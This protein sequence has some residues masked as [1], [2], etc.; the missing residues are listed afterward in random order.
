MKLV[1][2][3]RR[4]LSQSFRFGQTIADV[5][6][7]ILAGPEVPTDLVMEGLPSIPSPAH[8]RR[9][10]YYLY[11]TNAGVAGPG[12]HERYDRG[13]ARSAHGLVAT[14]LLPRCRQGPSRVR[15]SHPGV[16][17]PEKWIRGNP[18][19]QQ[20]GRGADSRLMVKPIDT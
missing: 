12:S 19:V 4:L 16:G 9:R 11:R 6:G 1:Q 2:E 15:G 17:R 20:G 14:R 8:C 13:Q 7:S 5:A 18:R 3:P 10:E